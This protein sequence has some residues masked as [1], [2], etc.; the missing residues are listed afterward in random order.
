MWVNEKLSFNRYSFYNFNYVEY[1]GDITVLSKLT[2]NYYH[3]SSQKPKKT[4][5]ETL[6]TLYLHMLYVQS[7]GVEIDNTKNSI[8]LYDWSK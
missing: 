2:K 6:F 3:E 4:Y 1:Y 8:L 7:I 5:S